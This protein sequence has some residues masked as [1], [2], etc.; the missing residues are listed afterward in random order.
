M[1]HE[2]R[3]N[4]WPVQL[5]LCRESLGTRVISPGNVLKGEQWAVLIQRSEQRRNTRFTLDA[6][7]NPSA[8]RLAVIKKQT[9]VSKTFPEVMTRNRTYHSHLDKGYIHAL[10]L[11]CGPQTFPCEEFFFVFQP[12]GRRRKCNQNEGENPSTW[13]FR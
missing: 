7:L 11:Q 10:Y 5:P 3:G 4:R 9:Q 8:Q 6:A 2:K 12:W 1:G 13:I